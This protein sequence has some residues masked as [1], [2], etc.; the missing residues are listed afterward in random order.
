MF[1]FS[2]VAVFA[3]F[4]LP[5]STKP[6]VV[7]T[8]PA[9]AGAAAS[10]ACEQTNKEAVQIAT[11]KYHLPPEVATLL[12]QISIGHQTPPGF[13]FDCTFIGC[14]FDKSVRLSHEAQDSL[15]G[16]NGFFN[17]KLIPLSLSRALGKKKETS[18]PIILNERFCAQFVFTGYGLYSYRN[19]LELAITDHHAGD[20]CYSFVFNP[21]AD[22]SWMLQLQPALSH[23]ASQ[24]AGGERFIGLFYNL[25]S[26]EEIKS[27]TILPGRK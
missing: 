7:P 9:A 10:Q 18:A 2:K 8:A 27:D 6:P 20:A 17:N 12:P 13:I 15:N 26:N 22:G 21:K 24:M 25:K 5:V 16:Y 1:P 14:Q 11:T 23:P 3:A 19:T 4:L